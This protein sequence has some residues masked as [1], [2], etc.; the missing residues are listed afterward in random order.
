MWPYHT[1][2]GLHVAFSPGHVYTVSSDLVCDIYGTSP[3]IL[4]YASNIKLVTI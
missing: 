3:P 1:G 4:Q 2:R